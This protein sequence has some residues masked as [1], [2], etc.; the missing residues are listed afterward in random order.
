MRRP[1]LLSPA[2]VVAAAL[3][4]TTIAGVVDVIDRHA[5]MRTDRAEARRLAPVAAQ[6]KRV[7]ATAALVPGDNRTTVAAALAAAGVAPKPGH[8]WSVVRHRDLG[9][10]GRPAIVYVDHQL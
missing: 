10:D 9:S 4:A 3:A 6:P 7:P 5:P 2:I 1:S 8:Y